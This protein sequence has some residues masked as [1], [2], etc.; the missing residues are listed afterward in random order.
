[1]Q[2]TYGKPMQGQ[3]QRHLQ[4]VLTPANP[5][6]LYGLTESTG[7]RAVSTP[8]LLGAGEGG[9]QC[10]RGATVLLYVHRGA[11]LGNE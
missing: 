10:S 1:M 5:T 11:A 9:G 6:Y 8:T 2:R 7:D 3:K 4:Q